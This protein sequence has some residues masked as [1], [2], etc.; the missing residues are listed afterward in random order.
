MGLL[1]MAYDLT[2]RERDICREVIAG[3][4]TVDIA[5]RLFIPATPCKIISSRCSARSA[6]AA[7]ASWSPGC[8]RTQR[9]ERVSP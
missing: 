1:L 9:V 4:S 7:A 8:E 6:Y 2:A 5:G 3:H